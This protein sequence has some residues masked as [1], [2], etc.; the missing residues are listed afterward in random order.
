M[1][2]V[3]WTKSASRELNEH[4]SYIA[5][6][7]P[8]NARLVGARIQKTTASLAELATGHFG[9]V[10]NTYEIVVPR[11]PYIVAYEKTGA[12]IVILRVIH[13][14][15]DWRGGSWPAES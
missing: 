13:A 5:E 9:R 14:A 15:R 11:T 1:R 10:L 4:L 8:Q 3:V 7:S 2:Q 6:D 12:M